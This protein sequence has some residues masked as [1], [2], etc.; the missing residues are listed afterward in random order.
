MLF[1]SIIAT[2]ITL[3]PVLAAAPSPGAGASDK[4]PPFVVN[5]IPRARNTTLATCSHLKYIVAA[6]PN[7]ALQQKVDVLLA[8]T[9][10]S[11]AHAAS[12]RYKNAINSSST[13]T[14]SIS[15]HV[16]CDTRTY[17]LGPASN[18]G[19]KN[20]YLLPRMHGCD[21]ATS[22]KVAYTNSTNSKRV[23]YWEKETKGGNTT[24]KT[25]KT[26]HAAAMLHGTTLL[27]FAVHAEDP[28]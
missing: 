25:Q 6:K 14:R 21:S 26:P 20:M 4:T 24:H 23:K 19:A 16:I 9:A 22:A 7:A 11:T 5:K 18:V 13:T 8:H 12:T 1:L 3:L 10:V 28:L 15:Y 17:T 2:R 27:H